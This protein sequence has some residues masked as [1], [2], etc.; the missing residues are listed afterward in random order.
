MELWVLFVLLAAAVQ[1][2]RFSLQKRLKGLGLST[3]GATFSRFL[4]AVPLAA[5][6]VALLIGMR[7]HALPVPG[8]AFWAYAIMGASTQILATFWTVALFSERSFAV[9]IAFTKTETILVALFSALL[10]GEAVSGLGIVA[11]LIGFC[12]VILLSRPPE[13]WGQGGV[14][15]RAT[16]L[17]L[18]AGGAFGLS[19]IGYRA[20]TQEIVSDDP[21]F[22]AAVALT[23]ATGF[24]TLAMSAWLRWREPGEITKVL[25]AW[26]GTLLVGVTGMLGSLFW[27]AAFALQNAAYVRSAGQV[28]LIFSILVSTIVFREIPRLREIAGMVLL[29]LSILLIIL[30][31]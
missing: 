19:A 7:G 27:F 21:L 25:S 31:P 16:I 4:F 11:I 29:V 13:G 17:G 8:P 26:R 3:G 15:N 12:G 23:A 5:G 2:L 14:F 10:L 30:Q 28:E 22:R 1:T 6:G 9:G 18:L 20:A 24:Q